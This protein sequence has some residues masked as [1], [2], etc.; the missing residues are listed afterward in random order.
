MARDSHA[1]RSETVKGKEYRYTVVF[2]SA[3][4]GG[5]CV[6]VP[7]LPGCHTHG[8]TLEEA[9][10]HAKEA[11]LVYLESL[12]D[13]G[14]EIPVEQPDSTVTEAVEVALSRA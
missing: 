10:E 7:S 13:D 11:I 2:E 14:E 12:Q 1:T 6:S 4:E 3:E 9:R 8:D 5:Y